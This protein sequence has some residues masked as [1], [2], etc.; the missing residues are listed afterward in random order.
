VSNHFEVRWAPDL[1]AAHRFFEKISEEFERVQTEPYF[2][3]RW[4][5][6]FPGKPE[7][8]IESARS[9][10]TLQRIF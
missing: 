10:V 4:K 7:C 1:T 8:P 3:T 9:S 5:S 6:R 2:D